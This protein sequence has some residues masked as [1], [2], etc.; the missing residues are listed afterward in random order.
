MS[1]CESMLDD[2]EYE[3]RF[4]NGDDKARDSRTIDCVLVMNYRYF[5]SSVLLLLIANNILLNYC[6]TLSQWV[7]STVVYSVGLVEEDLFSVSG[8]E[9]A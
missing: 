3:N 9:I 7:T 5:T 8:L 2:E 6:H 1:T 4:R